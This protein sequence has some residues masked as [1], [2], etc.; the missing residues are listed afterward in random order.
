MLSI[1]QGKE[2]T[3]FL[4]F[5]IEFRGLLYWIVSDYMNTHVADNR[6]IPPQSQDSNA[7]IL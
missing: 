2:G 5:P 7:Q 6:I 1:P 3:A 4:I